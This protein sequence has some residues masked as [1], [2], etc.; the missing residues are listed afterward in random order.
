M[1]TD[2]RQMNERCKEKLQGEQ[3]YSTGRMKGLLLNK[4]TILNMTRDVLE[5]NG[6]WT[7]HRRRVT[8]LN[9]EGLLSSAIDEVSRKNSLFV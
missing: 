1:C 2:E 4:Q 7:C 5:D 3:Y 6:R 8:Y 9:S